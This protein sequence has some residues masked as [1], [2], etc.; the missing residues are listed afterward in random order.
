MLHGGCKSPHPHDGEMLLDKTLY[1]KTEKGSSGENKTGSC[2]CILN[3][4]RTAPCE[5]RKA[6]NWK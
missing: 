1:G 5:K 3:V 4:V 2:E 6:T